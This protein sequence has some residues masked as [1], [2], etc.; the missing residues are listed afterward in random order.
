MIVSIRR[1][2]NKTILVVQ[3]AQGMVIAEDPYARRLIA[4]PHIGRGSTITRP[5]T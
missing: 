4:A 5:E 3:T 2:P 1:F